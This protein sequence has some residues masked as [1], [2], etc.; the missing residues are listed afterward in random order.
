MAHPVESRNALV[1]VD[2]RSVRL[3]N[4]DRVLWPEAGLTKAWLLNTYAR[5]APV[6]LPHLR[7]HPVTIWRYPQ[8]VHEQG[9]WQNECRSAPEWV[10]IYR[11][12]AKDGR[13]HRHCIVDDLSSLMWIVNLGTVELHP[14]LF[15]AAEPSRPRWLVFDLDPGEPATMRD[16][17]GVG[18]WLRDALDRQGLSSFPKTSG[19]KGLHVYVP[20]HTPVTFAETKAY[21]RTMASF[22]ARQHPD[23]VVD[24]QA[25][26]LRRGRVLVDWLQND[27]YRSMIAP[28][29]LRATRRP[30]LSTPV[31]WVDV[32][33]AARAQA[34]DPLSFTPEAVLDRVEGGGDAFVPVLHME[35][36]LVNEE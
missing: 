25:R 35:Q 20:L 3:T 7:G 29:S 26:D 9:W 1:D 22:L 12:T 2:G 17:C 28:Y 21:S 18:L 27:A 19:A 31:T 5:L 30:R 11:Y 36:R 23:V 34:D 32:D 24:R 8:G 14:F 13:E 33:R 16:A 6:L 10:H 4:L 15:A